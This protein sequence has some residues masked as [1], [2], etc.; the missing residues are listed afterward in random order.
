MHTNRKAFTLLEILLAVSLMALIF[1]SIF[2]SFNVVLRSWQTGTKLSES[3]NRGDYVMDQVVKALRSA[4]TP[5][6]S[7]S[8]DY[9]FIL[10]DNGEGVDSADSISWVKIGAALIG[11]Q[12]SFA[13]TPHRVVFT[14][15]ENDDYEDSLPATVKAWQVVGLPEDFDEEED[16]KSV[17]ISKDTLGFNFRVKDPE[18]NLAEDLKMGSDIE[19]E[20]LDEWENSNAIPELVE[21][22][23]FLKPATD[24]DEPL[25]LK[26]LVSI[27]IVAKIPDDPE[28]E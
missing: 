22:T 15:E 17:V 11:K 13:E 19:I 28:V 5:N 14:L 25:E 8:R 3:L 4:Y 18:Q 9:G 23:L 21:V 10:I 2:M 26:R 20:W 16:V 1:T 6:I 12:A 7:G 24:G 27:P